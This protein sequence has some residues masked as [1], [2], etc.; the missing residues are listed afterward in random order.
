M[1]GLLISRA[2]ASESGAGASRSPD[3]LNEQGRQQ[4]AALGRALKKVTVAAI[5][6]SPFDS[7]IETA[8]P[9]ARER[10]LRVRVRAGLT[11]ID[12]DGESLAEVQQRI[13]EE[14]LILANS[15]QGETIAIVTHD[16]PI[17]CA[18]AAF[19][20][21]RL[22]ALQSLELQPAHISAVGIQSHRRRVLGVNMKA[23]QV[24]V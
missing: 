8:T 14:L 12:A 16:G 19:S 20:G 5:Y 9:L 15:H 17:R 21:K 18:L 13:V 7:A 11:D 3:T 1:V 10:G 22:A 2:H 24:A 6:S 4:A 23:E